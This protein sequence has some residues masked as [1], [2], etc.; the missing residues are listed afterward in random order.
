MDQKR[1]TPAPDDTERRRLLDDAM[2]NPGVREAME[3]FRTYEASRQ[4]ADPAMSLLQATSVR[5]WNSYGSG[6]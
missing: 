1:A 6:E 5:T 2:K 4:A 3:V